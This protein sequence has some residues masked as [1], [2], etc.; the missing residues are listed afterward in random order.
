MRFNYLR[1]TIVLLAFVFSKTYGWH[2][3]VDSVSNDEMKYSFRKQ[4]SFNFLSVGQT[5]EPLR[6]KN[7]EL[8]QYR[9]QEIALSGYIPVFEGKYARD[10][11]NDASLTLLLNGSLSSSRSFFNFSS[12]KPVTRI[13]LGLRALY[14]SGGKNIWMVS[15]S[16][17]LSEEVKLIKNVVP[18]FFGSV[19]FTRMVNEYFSYK[20]GL[21]YTYLFNGGALLP[22]V[23][24]RVG[25]YQ[26]VFLN[27]QIPRDISLNWTINN[28]WQTGIFTRLSGGIYR[29]KVED[30][31]GRF[32]D[33]IG[34]V[35]LYRTDIL[36][37]FMINYSPSTNFY[38]SLN[39][40]LAHNR[41]INIAF[42]N[43]FIPIR[44][45]VIDDG[46]AVNAPFINL[47]MA[48]YFGKPTYNGVYNYLVEQKAVNNSLDPGDFNIGINQTTQDMNRVGVKDII[49][50]DLK[51]LNNRYLDVKDFLMDE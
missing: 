22:I 7:T 12:T 6:N 31:I 5:R 15:F 38:F 8:Y 24:F 25:D 21:S 29:F 48:I 42:S 16:P 50:K 44:G 10:Q 2:P 32:K 40:G 34:S 41:N 3:E 39:A 26:K 17:F 33:S 13:S 30:K 51:T 11:G 23:G 4:L 28:H 27:V 35:V 49:K 20:L 18:R 19:L 47:S 45:H 14:Y 43:E 37:G 46:R 1:S 9:F 36:T